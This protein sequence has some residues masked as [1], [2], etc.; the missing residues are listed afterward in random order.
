MTLRLT[1]S[2]TL[3]LG[4]VLT[5][6]A[7]C[8]AQADRGEDRV[9]KAAQHGRYAEAYEHAHHLAEENPDDPHLQELQR[10][11]QV[12]CVLDQG[13]EAVFHGELERALALFEQADTMAP[14]NR[15]VT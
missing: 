2:A 5:A 14:G 15:T 8:R 11:T 1:P 9:M 3:A 4:L 12:A 13:R 7:A 10:D 6:T